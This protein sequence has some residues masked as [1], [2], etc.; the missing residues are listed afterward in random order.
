MVDIDPP[1][2]LSDLKE[3]QEIKIG[4]RL[5]NEERYNSEN[6]PMCYWY[7]TASKSNAYSDLKH[8]FLSWTVSLKNRRFD[9]LS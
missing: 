2:K 8:D 4:I 6:Y 9:E 5:A 1:T 7:D 3:N